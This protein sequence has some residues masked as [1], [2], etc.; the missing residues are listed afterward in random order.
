[1][2]FLMLAVAL[3]GLFWDQGPETAEA[4]KKSGIECVHAAPPKVDGWKRA[5]F[6]ATAADLSSYQKLAEPGVE[7]KPDV[8]SASRAP[9]VISNAWRLLRAGSKPV[10]YAASKGHAELCAAE[11]FAYGA[12]ALVSI[13]PADLDRFGAML[14][15]L[16]R[17]DSPPLPIRANIGFIDDGSPAA[18]E[19]MNL[20]TRRN[21]LF[22]IVSAPDPSLDLNIRLGSAEYPRS[23]AAN[24]SEFASMVR[25]KLTD[26]KRLLRIY[27]SDVV[28]AHLTGD[29]SQA[30]LHLVNYGARK[31]E[32]LRVRLLGAYQSAKLSAPG[33]DASVSDL[34]AADGSTE[35]SIPVLDAYAIV[36]L[37]R[38]L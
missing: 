29:G 25:R 14:R 2:F 17:M 4:L 24:P 5:G 3:P 15:F 1:M 31:V 18:A 33:S 30:R 34:V 20:F 38:A 8:A 10:Y 37:Q 19:V 27:G 13:D 26:E 9:W 22:R 11:A 12:S 36:D 21:L 7:Y 6:C 28:I 23:A 32:G 16:K 35:F